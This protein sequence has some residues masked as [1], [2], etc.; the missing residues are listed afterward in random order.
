MRNSLHHSV[1]LLSMAGFL[2]LGSIPATA[3]GVTLAVDSPAF[4]FSPGNWSGDDGRGGSRYRQAWNSGAYFT[5]TWSTTSPTPTC[6]VLFDN[7]S[8][9]PAGA[10]SYSI[11]GILTDN[12]AVPRDTPTALL[13]IP[14]AGSGKHTLTVFV[15]NTAQRDRWV[16][17]GFGTNIVRIAGVRLDSQSEP[18]QAAAGAPWMLIVGDSIT[19]GIE[20]DNGADSNLAD[21]SHL[22]G[23]GLKAADGIDYCVSA[24]GYSGWIRH[25]DGTGDVPAYYAVSGSRDGKDGVYDDAGSRWNKIDGRTSLLDASGHLSGYGG[26]GQEPAVILINYIVNEC[27]SG[28]NLSD[29]QASVT[30]ALGA[31]RRAAPDAAILVL[32][33]PGIH[34]T[35]IYPNGAQYAD[36]LRHG[37]EAYRT[38]HRKDRSCVL[39]DLGPGLS[40]LLAS[41]LYGGGVHPHVYGHA[42]IAATL[43]PTLLKHIGVRSRSSIR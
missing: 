40:D 22:I 8:L 27:L 38:T 23:E 33:P 25:G 15:R 7:T 18:V 5:V 32:V 14:V 6:D 43:L 28:A 9:Q 26:T 12:V 10:I 13:P 41:P 42:A 19:E 35:R 30:Q 2:A 24:C 31:L 16:N 37:Y 29:A 36:A 4:H 34:N 21:Y 20:A 1:R 39:I 17:G 3:Q 11:D